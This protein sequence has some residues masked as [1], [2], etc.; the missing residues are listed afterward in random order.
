MAAHLCKHKDQ[1]QLHKISAKNSETLIRYAFT[2]VCLE[3]LLCWKMKLLPKGCFPDVE[4]NLPYQ[5]VWQS[6]FCTKKTKKLYSSFHKTCCHW[7]S[8]Q[9][10]C[11]LAYLSLFLLL[12]LGMASCWWVFT[13]S[14]SIKRKNLLVWEPSVIKAQIKC[15]NETNFW[16][17]LA[18]VCFVLSLF[19]S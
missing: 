4:S 14:Q 16:C 2:A 10:S 5:M 11:N 13:L 1:M 17:P 7:S 18:V 6:L 3:S 15:L 12:L 9:F 19:S 8:A